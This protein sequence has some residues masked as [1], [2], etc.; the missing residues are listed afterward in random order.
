MIIKCIIFER[1]KCNL[2][3]YNKNNK[4]TNEN[5]LYMML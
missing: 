1:I 5:K 2:E 3:A 4:L